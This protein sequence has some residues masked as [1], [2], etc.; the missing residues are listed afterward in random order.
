MSEETP[1][2]EKGRRLMLGH[3]ESNGATFELSAIAQFGSGEAKDVFFTLELPYFYRRDDGILVATYEADEVPEDQRG[4]MYV[5]AKVVGDTDGWLVDV[6]GEYTGK[7]RFSSRNVL[8]TGTTQ[9]LKVKIYLH[10][11]IPENTTDRKSVV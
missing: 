9:T 10:G 2:E 6:A 11:D 4:S 3:G 8:P 5:G 7:I 1:E